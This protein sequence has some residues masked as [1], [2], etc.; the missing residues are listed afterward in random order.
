[1]LVDSHCHLN[2]PDFRDDIEA[3]IARAKAAGIEVMQTICTEMAEFEEV[4]AIAER[5]EGVFCSVGVHPNDSGKI[6]NDKILQTDFA[7]EIVS[8]QELIEKTSRRKVIGIGETGLDYHYEYTDR[9]L[10]KRSFLEHIKAARVTGLPLIIHT[11]EAEEDTINILTEEI[12]KGWF[13]FLIHCFTSTKELADKAVE[14]GGYISLSGIIT[15]K[16]A[17][18]I[19]DAIIDVPLDRLLIE[20]DSPF[21]AP[22]PYRGK[23]NE[24]AYV[25]QVNKTLAGL[26]NIGEEECA[27]ITTANFFRL[28]D[29]AK[30]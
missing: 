24:P 28:F 10:Q 7:Q 21:L 25:L 4:Y 13:K 11:R 15:F 9:K 26:R 18:S 19:R 6:C 29:K 1:M 23:R 14:L 3:V 30:I 20:T 22:I 12:S 27:R 8:A 16:N 5:N 2:F 17:Q